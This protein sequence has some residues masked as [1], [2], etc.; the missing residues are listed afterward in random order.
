MAITSHIDQKV[1]LITSVITE[2]L[3]DD[4][5]NT[6]LIDLWTNPATATLSTLCIIQP[7]T[8]LQVTRAALQSSGVLNDYRNI[9]RR[10]HRVAIV[11]PEDVAYGLARMYEAYQAG[12]PSQ[13][14]VFR[15]EAEALAWLL[16]ADRA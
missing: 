4:D 7:G 11:A 10:V 15:A 12:S 1:G 8:I 5:I 6:Y 3:T 9:D 14:R 16:S 13:T 2:S